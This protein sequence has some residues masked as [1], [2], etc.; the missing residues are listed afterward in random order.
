MNPAH[1]PT[2]QLRPYQRRS[3]AH[4]LHEERAQGGSARHLWVQYNLPQNPGAQ[5][6]SCLE[7]YL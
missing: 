4:M 1:L 5:V 7:G 6:A 2:L 3:L